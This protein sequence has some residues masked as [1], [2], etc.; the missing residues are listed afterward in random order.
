MRLSPG[1][2]VGPYEIRRLLGSGGMGEVYCAHDPRLGRDVAIKV[3]PES[4]SSDRERLRRFEREARAAAALNHPGILA[5]YDVGSHGGSPYL[6]SELLEG[7]TLRQRLRTGVFTAEKALEVAGP[8]AQALAAAHERG[9]VHRDVKPENVFLTRDGHVKV[10]DFGLAKL[11]PGPEQMGEDSPTNTK[12]TASGTVLGTV[13]YMPP[14]QLR[15]QATDARSDVF[16][17]GVVLYEMLA[18]RRPFRGESGADVMAAILHQSPAKLVD[19]DVAVSPQL[20]RII[21]RCVQKRPEDRFDS[22]HELVVALEAVSGAESAG[23]PALSGAM[24]RVLRGWARRRW[25]PVTA[26]VLLAIGAAVGW[27]IW[28]SRSGTRGGGAPI[29]SLA[30]LPLKNYSGDASQDFLA[31]GMTDALIADLA[32]IRAL[33]VIS[34]TSMM[35]YR[36]T[37][38]PAPEIARELGVEGILE[39]SV[40]RLGSR[41]RVTAQ[42]I[43]ARR[44]RHLWASNYEREMR[45][46]L[47]LQ[48]E[49]VSAI[50]GEIRVQVTPQERERL[51]VQRTV[52][53]DAYEAVL[54]ARVLLEHAITE[55]EIRSAVELFRRATQQDP[56]YAPAWAGL[57]EATWTLAA[58]GFE[59]VPPGSV[60]EEARRAADRA[61]ELD[62][63][64]P[65]AHNGR[66][67]I[68]WDAEWDLEAAER[69]YRRALELRPGYAAAHHLYG[70]ML[71]TVTRFDEAREHLRTARGLDPFSPW[72][73]IDDCATLHFERRFD[74]AIEEC[75]RALARSPGNFIV[76]WVEGS[77]F[78]ARGEPDR[79]VAALEATIEPSGRNLNFLAHL[80]LAYGQAG[81]RE[82]ARRILRELQDLSKVR[83]VSPVQLAFAHLGLG[84]RDQAFRLLD[85]AVDERTPVLAAMWSGD[86]MFD[87]FRGDAR[88]EQIRARLRVLVKPMTGATGNRS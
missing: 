1:A 27:G 38:K 20:E 19:L 84:E 54:K 24:A 28:R 41:V 57:A 7:E 75:G 79:A 34:R 40:V 12:S 45:D 37:K 26:L 62:D 73:D 77:A 61:L 47:A 32:Q 83:Y 31:D 78:L 39:G 58:I 65:E 52:A 42:L 70:Q 10:L 81:R 9:I 46:V 66:A 53:P 88:Y 17:F 76:R 50:S 36:D 86:P 44:D 25:G 82:D 64:L 22:A 35:Q 51:A 2:R 30:V 5:V 29:T 14:E 67:L 15:G 16:S 48:R 80:G 55:K 49:V 33:R 18:G 68:A 69:H 11:R 63:L 87:G 6:V 74:R 72:N 8:L 71:V 59:F 85:R 56:L 4:V 60:R 13:S 21:E 3:L 23:R 43:D